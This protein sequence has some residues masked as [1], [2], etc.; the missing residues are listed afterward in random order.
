[1]TTEED[2]SQ[3]GNDER[4]AEVEMRRAVDIFYD[5]VAAVSR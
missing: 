5:V 4:I 2:A 3:H 1:M